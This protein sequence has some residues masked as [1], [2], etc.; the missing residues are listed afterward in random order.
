MKIRK[1][2]EINVFNMSALDLFAS[3]LG[4]FIL[5]SI[6]LMP[7]YLKK[8]RINDM[9]IVFVMDTTGSMQKQI[10]DLNDNLLSIVDI[11]RRVSPTLHMGFVAYRDN[12]K[13]E[14]LTRVF[15]LKEMSD[16]NM[17]KLTIF[18]KELDADGGGDI[19]EAIYAGLKEAI[20]MPWR[21]KDSNVVKIIVLIGDAPAHAKNYK[22]ILHNVSLFNSKTGKWKV[23]SIATYNAD[24]RNKPNPETASLFKDIAINGGGDYVVEKGRIME[25]ILLSALDTK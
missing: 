4:A 12:G 20:N 25:S 13:E 10:D 8:T 11:L 23:S 19:P 17:K 1:N 3:A 5:I 24:K 21:N 22:S 16:L 2:R 14:Y 9:D 7:Y 18:V 15:K 6:I